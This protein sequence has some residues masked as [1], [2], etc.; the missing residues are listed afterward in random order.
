MSRVLNHTQP[1]RITWSAKRLAQPRAVATVAR[2][3]RSAS[4]RIPIGERSATDRGAVEE[5]SARGPGASGRVLFFSSL[6]SSRFGRG[7][8]RQN[9]H[10]QATRVQLAFD[11]VRPGARRRGTPQLRRESLVGPASRRLLSPFGAGQSEGPGGA[12]KDWLD[13]PASA[14]GTL[15]RERLFQPSVL[16]GP[17]AVFLAR[18][19]SAAI[20]AGARRPPRSSRPGRA[21]VGVPSR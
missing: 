20:A 15:A 18:A 19:Y 7:R 3:K 2:G 9:A 1:G 6:D 5:R 17:G 10:G 8:T 14:C 12:A 21:S 4:D 11:G 13:R 16:A